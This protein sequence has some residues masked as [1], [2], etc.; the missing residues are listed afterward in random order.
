MADAL[1]LI[2]P[3]LIVAALVGVWIYSSTRASQAD[4]YRVEVQVVSVEEK[5]EIRE[6]RINDSLDAIEDSVHE[7]EVEQ[8]SFRS[9]VR[10]SLGIG[11][12]D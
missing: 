10:A 12:N 11:R 3:P 8:A 6:L 4:L 9:E 5:G 1:K 2:A 7:I